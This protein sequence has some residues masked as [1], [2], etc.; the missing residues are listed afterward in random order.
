MLS[1]AE[2][3]KLVLTKTHFEKAL[4]ILEAIEAKMPHAL[5]YAGQ[6]PLAEMTWKVWDYVKSGNVLT[7]KA[8]I[9]R[10]HVDLG[11]DG[12]S[13]VLG[14]L[15]RTG[16]I[17]RIPNYNDSKKPAYRAIAGASL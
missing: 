8:I 10:F 9:R 5:V 11:S 16:A 15:V 6:N 13:E 1:V 3:D 14:T 4:V 17:E 2:S 12:L 7:E